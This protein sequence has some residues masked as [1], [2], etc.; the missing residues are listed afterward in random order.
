MGNLQPLLRGSLAFVLVVLSLSACSISGASPKVALPTSQGAPLDPSVLRHIEPTVAPADFPIVYQ[1][2]SELPEDLRENLIAWTGER[3][4]SNKPEFLIGVNPEE[5]VVPKLEIVCQTGDPGGCT[6]AFRQHRAPG[7]YPYISTTVNVPCK[8]THLA[9]TQTDY[10][11]V[12]HYAG[13]TSY[14][15]GIEFNTNPYKQA[16]FAKSVVPYFKLGGAKTEIQ[17]TPTHLACDQ[18]GV[19]MQSFPVQTS[20]TAATTSALVVTAAFVQVASGTGCAAPAVCTITLLP[21]PALPANSFTQRCAGCSVSFTTSIAV[22]RVS[23]G[24][25]MSADGTY[26]GVNN[27][28]VYCKKASHPTAAISWSNVLVGNFNAAG[29]KAKLTTVPFPA[30]T[31]TDDPTYGATSGIFLVPSGTNLNDADASI[32]IDEWGQQGCIS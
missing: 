29:S 3:F 16:G 24:Q 9:A 30:V 11:Y 1:A 6:G 18:T 19:I 13:S 4:V 15:N 10:L 28:A 21:L 8:T 32:G 14:E 22:K 17:F 7:S 12:T 26:F 20:S 25:L 2:L 31:P 23:P 5:A 27:A